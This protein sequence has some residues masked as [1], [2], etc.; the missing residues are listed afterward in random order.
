MKH[1]KLLLFLIIIGITGL[2]PVKLFPQRILGGISAGITL[3]QVD[4][5]EIYGF[6]KVGFTGGPSIM[7]PFGKN[8]KWSIG[9]EL[10][11]TQ[12]G[13]YQ[14]G[15]E[16]DSVTT[17]DRNYKVRLD[18]LEIPVM[19]RFTDKKVISAGLGV[20]YGQLVYSKEWESNSKVTHKPF[21]NFD[22]GGVAEFQVR[23]WNRLWAGV[24][25]QYSFLP[26]TTY[27]Y[28]NYTGQSTWTRDAYNND[29]AIRL[30]WIFNQEVPPKAK[31]NSSGKTSGKKK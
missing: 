11:Y 18:Y 13:S 7:I 26:I 31:K 17:S 10:L 6:S 9:F 8:K 20:Y 16:G 21:S 29:I 30:S 24:R 2:L 23:I 15:L 27:N 12:K 28:I 4:G 22:F 1:P 25:Y 5:D 14:K 3:T 19:G